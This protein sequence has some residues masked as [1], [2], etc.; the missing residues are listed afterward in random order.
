NVANLA[1]D[2]ASVRGDARGV[3]L[4]V[5]LTAEL[6]VRVNPSDQL[7]G[8]QPAVVERLEVPAREVVEDLPPHELGLAG[9]HGVGV[10]LRFLDHGRDVDAA[11]HDLHPAPAAGVGDLV[12]ARALAGERRDGSQGGV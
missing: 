2:W 12:G 1:A 9:A 4:A 7:E 3:L 5:L 6:A 8:R 10:T 11:H